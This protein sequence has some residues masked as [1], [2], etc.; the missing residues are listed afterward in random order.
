[1]TFEDKAKEGAAKLGV[2]IVDVRSDDEEC[3]L[4]N[5]CG[6]HVQLA[7]RFKLR[8]LIRK[9]K[10]PVYSVSAEL[11]NQ[12]GVSRCELDS[13]IYQV[14]QVLEK[15]HGF[16]SRSEEPLE[17]V[18]ND[19]RKVQIKAYFKTE[20]AAMDFQDEIKKAMPSRWYKL[21][22]G[23]SDPTPVVDPGDL[24]RFFN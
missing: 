12:G 19:D 16:F 17:T 9:M 2:D 20:K 24:R 11:G 6:I 23:V 3:W 14:A 15:H 5:H 18:C 21:T 8:H 7:S 22:C 13:K 10:N 1:M 4:L